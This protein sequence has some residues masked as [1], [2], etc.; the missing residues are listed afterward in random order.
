MRLPIYYGWIIVAVAFVTMAIGVTARTAFSLF[1][2]PIVDEFGWD[3]GLT[4]GAFSFGFF[5][6]ALASPL[7]GRLMDRRG[8]RFVIECGVAMLAAGLLLAAFVDRPW[9][10]YVTLGLL[11]CLGAGCL[12]YTTQSQYLPH[13]FARRRALAISIAFSGAGVGAIV[14]MPWL[15]AIVAGEGWRAACTALGVMVL[16]VLGPINL[17]LRRRPEDIGLVPD[18]VPAAGAPPRRRAR[19]VDAHWAATDW[20]IGRATRSARFWLLGLGFF[21]AMFAW[22][23]VQ[24]HQ[25]KYLIESGF[26]PLTAAWALGAVAAVAIPGQIALGALSD[27]IGREW[28]WTI[29]CIG[30]VVCYACLIGLED[31]PDRLLLYVMVACQ[32]ALGYGLTSVMGAIV[33]E[34]FEGPQYATIFGVLTIPLMGGGAVGPW[35]TGVVHDLTGSYVPAFV[36]AILLSLVSIAAIWAAGP[37]RVRLVPG[38]S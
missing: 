24:V 32:G 26:D 20:T 14:L 4:A 18:G 6:N 28:I 33:V 16:V 34:M 9:Q 37:G 35:A 36:A 17:A 13:W 7:I 38:R 5:V 2:P 1:L 25:T 30:F 10:L 22:Y 8:P 3:R 19:I 23:A 15:Q 29:G 12:T 11:L 21:S 31:H 27:R